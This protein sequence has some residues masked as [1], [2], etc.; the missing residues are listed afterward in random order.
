MFLKIET[1]GMLRILCRSAGR[2]H[3][4]NQRREARY[5]R[6]QRARRHDELPACARYAAV[7]I[8]VVDTDVEGLIVATRPGAAVAGEVVLDGARPDSCEP[9]SGVLAMPATA[10]RRRMARHTGRRSPRTGRSHCETCPGRVYIRVSTL[11]GFPS[12]VSNHGR[13][14]RAS[15]RRCSSHPGKT[16]GLIILDEPARRAVGQVRG[17]AQRGATYRPTL[18]FAFGED[19]ALLEPNRDDDEILNC[20]RE[21]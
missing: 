9:I 12:R 19:R 10:Q 4:R 15:Q 2:R 21:G 11:S 6:S 17:Q 3:F 16:G 1:S 7:P 18:V 13:A 20:R 8:A 14:G 5:V